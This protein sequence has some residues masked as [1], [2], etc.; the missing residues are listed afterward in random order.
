MAEYIER[1]AVE[2]AVFIKQDQERQ[3]WIEYLKQFRGTADYSS[4]EQAVDNWL[5]GYGEAVE[6]LLA[7]FE[8]LSTAD[9]EKV[10][11]C[12]NCKHFITDTFKRTMCNRT[13]TMF[14]MNEND[15][16]SYGEKKEGAE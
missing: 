5:R 1:E 7:I 11:R 8:T 16:C 4:K 10:V 9:V 12:K 15:F 14:E 6:N 13:F 3:H 2:K